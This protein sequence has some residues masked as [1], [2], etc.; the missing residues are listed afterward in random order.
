MVR[1][2]RRELLNA[3]V[4]DPVPLVRKVD[5]NIRRALD[6]FKQSSQS[7]SLSTRQAS[8]H[9]EP[10]GRPEYNRIAE[11][12]SADIIDLATSIAERVTHPSGDLQTSH[13]KAGG[14]DSANRQ[15]KVYS[16]IQSSELP[17]LDVKE[18]D[19]G[20]EIAQPEIKIEPISGTKERPE[21][22]SAEPVSQDCNNG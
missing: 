1:P 11:P 20:S 22:H 8:A 13:S 19:V 9:A 12:G 17:A 5:S 21:D 3:P 15:P 14:F 4:T 18:P 6:N 7:H 2:A 10:G 16:F